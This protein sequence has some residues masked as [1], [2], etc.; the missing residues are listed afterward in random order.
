MKMRAG[1]LIPDLS[2]Y[3]QKMVGGTLGA[4]IRAPFAIA[5]M[6]GI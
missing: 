1:R 2:S 5:S 3:K 6:I 4:V